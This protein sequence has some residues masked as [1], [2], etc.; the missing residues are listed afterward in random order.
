[1]HSSRMHTARSLTASHSIRLGGACQRA[2]CVPGWGGCA[3]GHACMSAMHAPPVDRMTDACESITLPQTSF[4]CV[5]KVAHS[6]GDV[7][8]SSKQGY[9]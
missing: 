1:M 4:A 6:G 2:A 5:N 7:T 9:R 3:R 8:R